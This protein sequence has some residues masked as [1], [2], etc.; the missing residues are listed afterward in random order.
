MW[1]LA[2]EKFLAASLETLSKDCGYTAWIRADASG[3]TA[4]YI[5]FHYWSQQPGLCIHNKKSI[6]NTEGVCFFKMQNKL[7]L[8]HSNV[9]Y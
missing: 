5:I 9:Y 3:A 6:L 8:F 4:N 7:E 1:C 2:A